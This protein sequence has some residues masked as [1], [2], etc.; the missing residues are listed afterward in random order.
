MYLD[1]GAILIY[2]IG[3]TSILSCCAGV[4]FYVYRKRKEKKDRINEYYEL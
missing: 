2:S 4:C 1:I 3:G